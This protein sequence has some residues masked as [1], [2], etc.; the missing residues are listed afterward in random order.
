M[1]VGDLPL[2]P[3]LRDH[4]PRVPLQPEDSGDIDP[5]ARVARRRLGERKSFSVSFSDLTAAGNAPPA[6][7]SP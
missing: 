3:Q 4:A 5:G 7:N 2:H 1:G 6:K